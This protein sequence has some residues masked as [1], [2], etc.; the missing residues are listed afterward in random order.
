MKNLLFLFSILLFCNA[1]A[2]EPIHQCK[3]VIGP[4]AARITEDSRVTAAKDCINLTTAT[5]EIYRLS[6]VWQTAQGVCHFLEETDPYDP[7]KAHE[8]VPAK[9]ESWIQAPRRYTLYSSFTPQCEA[10]NSSV[11]FPIISTI[12]DEVIKKISSLWR[13]LNSNEKD[14]REFSQRFNDATGGAAKNWRQNSLQI[15]FLDV[16]E[17]E[18]PWWRRIFNLETKSYVLGL[19][20]GCCTLYMATL[21]VKGEAVVQNIVPSVR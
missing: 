5:R 3:I 9:I 19:K 7:D 10:Q 21:Q 15:R 17:A 18:S 1:C 16:V 4:N 20:E 14:F 12:P 2:E 13:S 11:Y 8:P 6:A